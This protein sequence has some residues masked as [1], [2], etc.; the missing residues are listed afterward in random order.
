MPIILTIPVPTSPYSSVIE[1]VLNA[2][3][4]A[5]KTITELR[6]LVDVAIAEQQLGLSAT[7]AEI[8]TSLTNVGTWASY[9]SEGARQTAITARKATLAILRS[10]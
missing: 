6:E 8:S 1:T 3:G 9:A 4:L 5:D 10:A 2:D 7:A